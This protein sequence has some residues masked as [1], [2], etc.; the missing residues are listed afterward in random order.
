MKKFKRGDKVRQVGKAQVMVVE[1]D[2]GL[3]AVSTNPG[4]V[5]TLRGMIICSWVN[6]KGKTIQKSFAEQ[7][8]EVAS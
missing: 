1:G 4:N 3:A 8:L 2:A 7:G 6:D 5:A